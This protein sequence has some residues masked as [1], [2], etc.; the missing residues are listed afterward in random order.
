MLIDINELLVTN[1]IVSMS[2]VTH[3]TTISNTSTEGK[4][5]NI[6]PYRVYY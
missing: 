1:N 4:G 3:M 6:P 2:D 5:T